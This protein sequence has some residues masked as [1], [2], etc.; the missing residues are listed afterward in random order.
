VSIERI[1]DKASLTEKGSISWF[2][3]FYKS[4][5]TKVGPTL[6]RCTML[7][8][9]WDTRHYDARGFFV[10]KKGILAIPQY[11]SFNP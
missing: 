3:V 5:H 2:C 1:A 9:D 10:T 4:D 7:I 11:T 6:A 8:V